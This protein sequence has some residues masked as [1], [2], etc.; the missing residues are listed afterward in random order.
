VKKKEEKG[1]KKEGKNLA[2]KARGRSV[3]LLGVLII[4][5]SRRLRDW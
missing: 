5:V 2:P 1:K 4:V 3:R